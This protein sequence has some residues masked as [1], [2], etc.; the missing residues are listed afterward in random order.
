MCKP[1]GKSYRIRYCTDEQ[2]R[3]RSE[4]ADA[5]Y[6]S[7]FFMY[8]FFI[9]KITLYLHVFDSLKLYIKD[10]WVKLKY[11]FFLIVQN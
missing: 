7:H 8:S 1:I 10:E 3:T 4:C 2:Q 9:G 6:L 11:I 5:L